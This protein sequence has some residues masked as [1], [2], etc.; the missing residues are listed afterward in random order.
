[1]E[2][3]VGQVF[4]QSVLGNYPQNTL[5]KY[6]LIS[7]FYSTGTS[8]KRFQ[9]VSGMAGSPVK[10]LRMHQ[11]ADFFAFDQFGEVAGGVHV[12]DDDGHPAVGAEGVGGLVHDLE[13]F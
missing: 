2:V 3:R 12:E 8:G 10:A 13:V 6:V 4:M 5:H 1:M 9:G 11:R 7:C